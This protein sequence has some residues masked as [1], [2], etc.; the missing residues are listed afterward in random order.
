MATKVRP[1]TPSADA[2]HPMPVRVD[3]LCPDF[4]VLDRWRVPV[5]CTRAEFPH[6]V[7]MFAARGFSTDSRL[8]RAL[9][10]IRFALGRA[11]GWDAGPPQPIPGCTETTV[12]ARL[13]ERGLPLAASPPVTPIYLFDD[14]AL[15]E[16][17]NKT[18]HALLHLSWQDGEVIMSV[19]VKSRGWYS[20][21][22]LAA[23]KPF[24]HAVVYP[25]LLRSVARAWIDTRTNL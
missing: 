23:I 18:V 7:R 11:L 1:P 9:F 12:A 22:Y 2:R 6:F 19:R 13:T 21:A 24:R 8:T 25:A 20:T 17:A 5:D 4:R 14:E 3:Q 10:R 15:F 16:I